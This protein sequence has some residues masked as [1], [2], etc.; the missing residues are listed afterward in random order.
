[1]FSVVGKRIILTGGSRGIGAAVSRALVEKGAK[2][3]ILDVLQDQGRQHVEDLNKKG[4]GQA[5]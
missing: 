3:C 1:M 4:P 2:V 5:F